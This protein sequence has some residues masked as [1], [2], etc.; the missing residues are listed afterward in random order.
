LSEPTEHLRCTGRFLPRTPYLF[1]LDHAQNLSAGIFGPIW[2]I[3]SGI[4]MSTQ[5][6]SVFFF[7][8]YSR[9]HTLGHQ[10]CRRFIYQS[11]ENAKTL[12]FQGFWMSVLFLYR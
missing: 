4:I 1:I 7:C 11:G 9:T 8:S 10:Q 3:S 2:S 12:L 6:I 5:T